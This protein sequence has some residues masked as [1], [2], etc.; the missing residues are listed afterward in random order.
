M[1]K[2]LLEITVFISGAVVMVFEL[3]GSRLVAPYLGTSIYVWTALIGV[4]LA[5]LSLGY[6]LGGKLADKSATY[7]NLGWVIFL[8]GIGVVIPAFI[9][10]TVLESFLSLGNHLALAALLSALI[11]FSLPSFLLGIVSPYAVRLKIKDVSNSG[12]TVGNLYALSTAGSIAGTF[13]AGFLI[14]PLL[15]VTKIIFLLAAT[16]VLL[17][18]FL[19]SDKFWPRLFI[20]LFLIA[21]VGANSWLEKKQYVRT[22]QISYSTPY[23]EV[24]IFKGKDSQTGRPTLNLSTDRFGRQSTMFLDGDDLSSEY[25]RFY[26]LMEHFNPNFKD[27]LMIGGAAYIY[28]NY[29]LR[30]YP[31]AKI[32]VVEI[33]PKLTQLARQYFS[34]QDNPRLD[35]I[36]EDGRVFLNQNQKK[37]DVVLM[38]AFNSISIPPQLASQEAAQKVADSLTDDGVVLVNIISAASGKR[39][40][41]LQAEYM[42]YQA[43]F[44]QVLVFIVNSPDQPEAAQNIMLVALKSDRKPEL[45]SSNSDL[46]LLLQHLYTGKIAP[47]SRMITDDYAPVDYYMSQ[48]LL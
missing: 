40:A 18:L 30:Q 17:S 25:G 2:Y 3:V 35:I 7:A 23:N 4:I 41:F 47:N 36:H 45:V 6:W 14:I 46:N 26:R 43:V 8:A 34:L 39:S 48:V 13:L 44:P 9:K 37:Y 12:Q 21:A 38:D 33:D 11:L 10:T 24:S 22:S 20:L 16:L 15:G 19:L 31:E 1:K 5:S 28:P 32:D 29:Y 42:A 27:T